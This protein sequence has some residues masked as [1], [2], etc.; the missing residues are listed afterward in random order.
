MT[1]LVVPL[2]P[3]PEPSVRP[4]AGRRLGPPGASVGEMWLAGPGLRAAAGLDDPATLDEL[5]ARHGAAL[6]GA[7]GMALLG[8]RFPLI[9][10]LIDSDD[11]LSLQVHPDDDLARD[12]YGPDA[13]GKAEAWV[14][15]D[16]GPATELVTGPSPDLTVPQLRAVVADGTMQLSDCATTA[17]RAG[18]TLMIRAG[19]IHAIGAG[20]FVYEIEQPSD[21]TF[22]ISDWGR[23]TGRALHPA[24]SL[25]A[26]VPEAHALPVGS[27]W[28]LDGGALTVRE[29]RLELV[30][31]PHA[32]ERRPAGETLEVVTVLRGS[33]TAH[34]DGW[35][36]DLEVRDTIVVPAAV[37]SYTL[38]PGARLDRCRGQHSLTLAGLRTRDLLPAT[39]SRRAGGEGPAGA[40]RAGAPPD[41][42]P[43]RDRRSRRAPCRPGG[44][45]GRPRPA[46]PHHRRRA[47]RTGS[48]PRRTPAP[49]RSRARGRQYRSPGPF[50]HEPGD[51]PSSR[52]R[53]GHIAALTRSPPHR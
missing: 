3:V 46:G 41:R 27:G 42:S 40:P 32:G 4:W 17:A 15:L 1:D 28:D 50:D 6:V 43:R 49:C 13:V 45:G 2:R 53:L 9:V 24:E 35:R 18:D 44:R 29:F 14:V 5:A 26:I 23:P 39:R 20:S 25:R 21:L 7:R 22:R 11:W 30:H 34:G 16:A 52:S 10:K 31:G 36:V 48:I 37:P 51:R 38:E 33:A 12:L 19:T 8:P 47:G